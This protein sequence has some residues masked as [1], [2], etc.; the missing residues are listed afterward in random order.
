MFKLAKQPWVKECAVGEYNG[1]VPLSRK[2]KASLREE[3]W[4][5]SLKLLA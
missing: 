4:K 3:N 2:V 1:C 5:K